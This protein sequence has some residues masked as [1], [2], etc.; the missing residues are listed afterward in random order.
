MEVDSFS[1]R[2][3]DEYFA[4]RM[5]RT[6]KKIGVGPVVFTPQVSYDLAC[7]PVEGGIKVARARMGHLPLAGPAKNVVVRKVYEAVSS[8]KEWNAVKHV[9]ETKA[10]DGKLSLVMI[11][12]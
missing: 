7:M 10:V 12:K 11:R 6:L 2:I 4:V 3:M 8:R 9:V 1:V 5:V